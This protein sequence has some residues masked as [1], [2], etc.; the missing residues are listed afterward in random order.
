MTEELRTVATLIEQLKS[1]DRLKRLSAASQLAE[2]EGKAKE[3]VPILKTW[4]GS[5]DKYRHVTAIGSILRIDK[6][7]ADALIPLLIEALE[8]DGL[9]QWQA[10]IQLQ[11]LGELAKPAIPAMERLLDGDTTICWIASDALFQITGDDWSVIKVG[12]RLLDDPDELIRV[13]GV[14][15][16]MQMGKSVIPELE[17]VAV[18]DESDLVR[19]RA[20]AALEEIEG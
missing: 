16:L 20:L 6:S 19:N 4:I 8:F 2:L 12:H 13:V 17:S 3:T 14:E 11:S 5:E 15:H 9:E 10:V 18:D 7:E 1:N